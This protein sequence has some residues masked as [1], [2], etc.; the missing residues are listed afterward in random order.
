MNI[1]EIKSVVGQSSDIPEEISGRTMFE[2]L[3]FTADNKPIVKNTNAIV[4]EEQKEEFFANLPNGTSIQGELYPETNVWEASVSNTKVNTG[5][6]DEVF[7]PEVNL[8]DIV[9]IPP[10]M[11]VGDMPIIID[12][13]YADKIQYEYEEAGE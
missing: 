9:F 13:S 1:Y 6:F 10:K 12:K 8:E 2:S 4:T 3:V 7:L 11:A 5:S